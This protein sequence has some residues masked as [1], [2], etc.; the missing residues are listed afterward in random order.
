[1][2][3]ASKIIFFYLYFSNSE[4]KVKKVWFLKTLIKKSVIYMH[5]LYIYK[6][7]II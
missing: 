5:I 3:E 4:K 1:M 7:H 2:H 6:I